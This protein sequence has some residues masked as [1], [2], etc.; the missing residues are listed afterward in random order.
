MDPRCLHRLAC[1]SPGCSEALVWEGVAVP[2]QAN[3]FLL[4]K[5]EGWVMTMSPAEGGFFWRPLCQAHR[6]GSPITEDVNTHEGR[7]I[8]FRC[9]GASG[10]SAGWPPSCR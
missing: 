4:A 5:R 3:W 2:G 9:M 7:P 8:L 10:G 1:G 6:G